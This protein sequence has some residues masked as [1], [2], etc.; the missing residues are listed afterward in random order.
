MNSELITNPVAPLSNSASTVIPSCV[1]ILSSPIFTV[2]SLKV[3][4]PTFLT[5]S[6]SLGA[7]AFIVVANILYLLRESSQGVLDSPPP[8]K[9]FALS[10]ISS[11]HP[12]LYST[13]L[14]SIGLLLLLF[15]Q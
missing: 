6:S 8:F 15:L 10:T 2:T 11:I 14:S 1:S 12:L 7:S 3:L 4:S 13:L 9:L 5:F